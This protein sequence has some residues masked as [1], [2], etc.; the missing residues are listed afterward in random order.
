M[1][2]AALKDL[3]ILTC[4]IP[5]AYL[6]VKCWEKIW[7]IAGTEFGV[8]EGTLMIVKMAMYGLK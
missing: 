6:N 2:V 3:D 7:T 4:D 5:N 1:T 8:E